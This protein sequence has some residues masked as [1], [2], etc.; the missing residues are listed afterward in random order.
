MQLRFDIDGQVNVHCD[1]CGNPLTKQLWEE[2][3]LIVKMV[4]N[5]EEMNDQEEDPDIYY[6]SRGESHLQIADWLYEFINLSIPMQNV[7]GEDAK[8]KSLCN[9]EVIEKL[10]KMEDAVR[11]DSNPLWQGLEKFKDLE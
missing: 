4:D 9:Q 6:I 11:K 8:G 5:P 2:F 10:R 7:C 3:N 1:R